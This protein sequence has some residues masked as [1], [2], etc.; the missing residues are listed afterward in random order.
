MNSTEKRHKNFVVLTTQRSGSTWLIGLLNQLKN[1]TAC[2]ELFLNRSRKIGKK[3]WDS[4]FAYPR[5]IEVQQKGWLKLRPW[6]V[7]AYLE[8]LYSQPGAVG[9]K[10]M[11][12]HLKAHPEILAYLM[13]KNISVIH[14]I[15]Q[16]YLDILI[17]HQVKDVTGR[18]HVLSGEEKPEKVLVDLETQTLIPHLQQLQ[19]KNE[20]I[21]KIL[22][23]LNLHHIEVIYED[24]VREPDRFTKIWKFLDLESPE[25]L[26]PAKLVKIRRDGHSEVIRNY[27]EVKAVLM[28]S[29]F[30]NLIH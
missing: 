9:F 28:D 27:N 16:N 1:T 11:Y 21:R 13:Y 24:L 20:F 30:A 29:A 3:Y 5:F 4:D 26:P 23:Q 18:A 22:R 17:S 12:S 15:R 6:S 10:L 19:K 25:A 8:E 7:F 14:L 2:D